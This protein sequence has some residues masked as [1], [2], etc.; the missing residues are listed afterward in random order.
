MFLLLNKNRTKNTNKIK[1]QGDFKCERVVHVVYNTLVSKN[2][3]E[4][5]M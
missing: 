2:S 1:K 5:K 3:V 4:S